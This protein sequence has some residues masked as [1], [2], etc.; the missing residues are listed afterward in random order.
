[1]NVLVERSKEA[2]ITVLFSGYLRPANATWGSAASVL[3]FVACWWLLAAAG[4][5]WWS[6]D[7]VLIPLGVAAACVLSVLWGP[8]AIARYRS[9]DPRPFVLDEFAGQ[10]IA[11]LA[12][13]PAAM[14]GAWGLTAVLAG[15][16]VLFRVFDVLKVP[17][18][19]QLERLPGGWGVLCDDLAAGVYANLAG[20]LLWRLTPL[21]S[22]L[23]LATTGPP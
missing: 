8:W 1:M 3:I 12:L 20:Q 19:A 6:V 16:W 17:P 18:A 10:W 2:A 13:P 9:S 15:Q 21:A 4:A 5:P 11:L 22:W 7:V 14:A 23:G